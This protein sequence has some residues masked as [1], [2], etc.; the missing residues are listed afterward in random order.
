MLSWKMGYRSLSFTL[1]YSL[2]TEQFI[3]TNGAT[4]GFFVL[5]FFFFFPFGL[6]KLCKEE[7]V[8]HVRSV[9]TI[10]F[11]KEIVFS[12]SSYFYSDVEATVLQGKERI[13]KRS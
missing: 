12:P 2:Y 11:K 3:K 4:E 10:V 7:S 9:Q 1:I 13:W 5:V 6:R 8:S